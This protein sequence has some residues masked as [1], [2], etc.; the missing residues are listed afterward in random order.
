MPP[1]LACPPAQEQERLLDDQI[2]SMSEALQAL[3]RAPGNQPHLY[4][5]D[6]DIVTLPCYERDTIFAVRAPPD[7]MLEV[8]DPFVELAS[9]TTGGGMKHKYR[10]AGF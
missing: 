2:S 5:T 4:V 6:E 10:W 1:C 8:P 7:A 3:C 9:P